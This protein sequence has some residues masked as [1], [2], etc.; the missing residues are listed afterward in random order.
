MSARGGHKG[1]EP[2][3][4]VAEDAHAAV[5][6]L[7]LAQKPLDGVIRVTALVNGTGTLVGDIGAYVDKL[8]LAAPASAHILKDDDVVGAQVILEYG[9][10]PERGVAASVWPA[11]VWR[12]REQYRMVRAAVFRRIYGR[13]ETYAVPHGYHVFVLDVVCLEPCGVYCRLLPGLTG[14][15]R[16]GID[17]R[18]YYGYDAFHRAGVSFLQN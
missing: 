5:M 18:Y 15:E 6:A 2:G 14:M 3:I 12:A 13:I 10:L 16:G 7:Q 8:S 1:I 11:A 9:L 4:G 17:E